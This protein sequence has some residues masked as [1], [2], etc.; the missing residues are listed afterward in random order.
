VTRRAQKDRER[1][2]VEQAARSLGGS[3]S[4]VG[5]SETP[6]FVVESGGA[7]FGLEVQDIFKG[8]QTSA[9]ASIKRGESI[10]HQ[11]I[12]SMRTEYERLT[13]CILDVKF[14]GRV[15]AGNRT[16]AIRK[17][18]EAGFPSLQVGQK[19][20]IELSDGLRVHATKAYRPNWFSVNDRVG[21]VDLNP[22]HIIRA[23]IVAKAKKLERYKAQ[24][25]SDIRLLLIA[26]RIQNSGK[27]LLE[28]DARFRLHGFR[29]V[30]FYPYPD[31]VIVLQEI[32]DA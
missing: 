15:S 10:R 3:W 1:F 28:G 9:G 6:D 19:L 29:V 11:I 5:D 25:G 17:L 22:G 7:H 31:A 13:G 20:I 18:V 14:V 16:E 8:P 23:A 30:Y 24:A 12:D 2:F 26:N 4:I 27:L 32:E 21:F